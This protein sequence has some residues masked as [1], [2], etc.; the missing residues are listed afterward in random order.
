MKYIVILIDGAGDNPIEAL[1]NKTPLMVADMPHVRELEKKAR[2][3][4]VQTIPVGMKP[5]SDVANLSVMGYDPRKYHTGRS[6]L[7]ALSLGIDLKEGDIALR[8]NL[9]TLGGEEPF[10]EKEMI[11][12]SGGEITTKEAASLIEA[13]QEMLKD[14]KEF[15]LYQGISYRHALI[16]HQGSLDVTLTQPH[17]ITG[18]KVGEYFPKGENCDEFSWLIKE[19]YETLKDHPSNQKRIAEGKRPANTPWVWG[20]GT[21]PQLDNFSERNGLKGGAITAVDLIKGIAVGAGMKVLE[22]EGATGTLE[23]NFKGKGEKALEGLLE[24]GL[25]YIYVHLEAPDECG[26]QKDV[27]GKVK[28]LEKIDRDVIGPI[29][30][31]LEDAREDFRLLIVP[32]HK[33]PL[34]IGSHV[35]DPVPYL[36]YDSRKDLG[37]GLVYNEAGG[38]KGEP[39]GSG[40]LLHGI[41]IEKDS[42][43]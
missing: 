13:L 39:V 29:V 26:H 5:G 14:K 37:N 25:D 32:D 27:E 9:V 23:T 3:G 35:S 2:I 1:G 6:P 34:A 24:G 15:D 36:L 11:D 33:T 41:L 20:E 12:Y 40:P 7:E 19:G 31:G 16:W 30:K 10:S 17:D 18:K 4:E 28:S 22:V 8:L 42:E 38:E 43:K 21:K